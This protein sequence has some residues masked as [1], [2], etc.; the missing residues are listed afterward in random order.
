MIFARLI[1]FKHTLDQA[2]HGLNL[3]I[4]VHTFFVLSEFHTSFKS[5]L[6]TIVSCSRKKVIWGVVCGTLILMF[7]ISGLFLWYVFLVDDKS[8]I[9][10]DFALSEIQ[11]VLF[12]NFVGPLAM[13]GYLVGRALATS[14]RYKFNPLL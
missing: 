10:D 1:L 4:L 5:T 7:C 6:E 3:G 8:I 12:Y 13:I 9:D 2:I 14:T 11:S